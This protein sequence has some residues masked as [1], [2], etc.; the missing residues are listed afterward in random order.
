MQMTM[1][2][3]K[4]KLER[5]KKTR[6]RYKRAVEALL[7]RGDEGLHWEY[8]REYVSFKEIELWM[9]EGMLERCG[10]TSYRLTEKARYKNGHS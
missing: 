9:K 1:Q 7:E 3:M 2:E 5:D 6:A 4:A 8:L 10:N